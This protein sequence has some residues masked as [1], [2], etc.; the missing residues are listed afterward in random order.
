M[1]ARFKRTTKRELIVLGLTGFTIYILRVLL[2]SLLRYQKR[3]TIFYQP[4]I[5]MAMNK[6]K[7]IKYTDEKIGKIKIIPDFLPSPDQLVLKKESI[8]IKPSR[9]R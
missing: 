9:I 1:I 5:R 8:K 3:L 7:K 4:Y 6:R 2:P